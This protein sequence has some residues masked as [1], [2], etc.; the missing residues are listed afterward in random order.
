MALGSH[1]LV[2]P[3]LAVRSVVLVLALCLYTS[4][5]VAQTS[6]FDWNEISTIAWA[7]ASIVPAGVRSAD[8]RS[9]TSDDVGRIRRAAEQGNALAQFSL[10][11]AYEGG[12][13]VPLDDE[14]ACLWYRKAADQ[15]FPPAE[16]AVGMNFAR[17][18]GVQQ[19]DEEAVEWVRRAAVQGYALAQYSLG[20][21]NA[22]GKG[23]DRNG[24][25][26]IPWFQKAADQ[27]LAE[28]QFKFGVMS[29]AFS[30]LLGTGQGDGVGAAVESLRKAADQDLGQAQFALGLIYLQGSPLSNPDTNLVRDFVES[31]KWLTIC[32]KRTFGELQSS[33]GRRR[34]EVERKMTSDAIGDGED[35]AL[36]WINEFSRRER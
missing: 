7:V 33:C 27:G 19:D 32:W 18:R 23:I 6:R 13:G 26:S 35:R 29:I 14:Q 21:A 31:Y 9:N 5:A 25:A 30:G 8:E 36:E 11:R 2:T 10:G 12:N 3:I 34:F 20:M 24:R 28:A 22:L 17:G 4:F 15:R 1:P 16:F